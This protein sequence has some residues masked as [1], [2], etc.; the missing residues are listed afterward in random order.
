MSVRVT[1][2]A[3]GELACCE[4]RQVP[5]SLRSEFARGRIR[6]SPTV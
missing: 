5:P 4:P 1:A 2:E 3:E 6:E